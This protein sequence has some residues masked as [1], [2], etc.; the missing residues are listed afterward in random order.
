MDALVVTLL[1]L[2]LLAIVVAVIWVVAVALRP[3][4]RD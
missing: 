2:S 3:T 1:T 4:T